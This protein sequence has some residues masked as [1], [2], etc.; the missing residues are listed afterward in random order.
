MALVF[1]PGVVA[2]VIQNEHLLAQSCRKSQVCSSCRKISVAGSTNSSCKQL[3]FS[4]GFWPRV[5]VIQCS[6]EWCV[7]SC[8]NVLDQ[9]FMHSAL[10]VSSLRTVTK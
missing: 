10:K 6:E 3:C 2:P 4:S 7:V 8:V 9:S 5:H 1:W